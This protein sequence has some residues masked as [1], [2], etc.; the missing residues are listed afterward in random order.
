MHGKGRREARIA[1]PGRPSE[2]YL[3]LMVTV[4]E[5]FAGLISVPANV[6]VPVTGMVPPAATDT[7]TI[8]TMVCPPAMLGALQV[9]VPAVPGAGPWQLPMLVV[10]DANGSDGGSV[11]LKVT[12]FAAMLRLSLICHVN[13]SAVPTAG[14]PFC[15]AP[16]T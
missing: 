15:A 8:T 3:A 9:I 12:P 6:A 7:F 11:V 5:L 4:N 10:T 16:P 14:P 13:V 2:F 1:P